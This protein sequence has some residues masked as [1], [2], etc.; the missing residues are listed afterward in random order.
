MKIRIFRPGDP[1]RWNASAI[2]VSGGSCIGT[3]SK[4]NNGLLTIRRAVPVSCGHCDML[5]CDDGIR[6]EVM[7]RGGI[8]HCQRVS[9]LGPDGN[10]L[11][12]DSPFG[13]FI[14][15]AY[16]VRNIVIFRPG[17]PVRWNAEAV[18]LSGDKRVIDLARSN[19]GPF[20]IGMISSV[21]CA[22]C[23]PET[24][25][26]ARADRI[27]LDGGI[28][29]SHCQAVS[30]VDSRGVSIGTS[31]SP[32]EPLFISASYFASEPVSGCC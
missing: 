28:Q 2:A 3:L 20:L 26:S 6:K 19:K 11:D 4:S 29:A 24:C 1:V 21:F 18:S 27:M 22:K 17:D 15:A 32:D 7:A 31:L 5:R 8:H 30:L 13:P 16:L 23:N 10:E 12:A 25:D 9:L 14:S